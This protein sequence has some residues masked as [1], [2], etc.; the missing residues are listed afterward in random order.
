MRA[1]LDA[2]GATNTRI[3]VTS[4]LDEFSIAA[5]AA[6]PVDGYGVGTQLV[7]GSG[8]PTCGFVYK[9]VAREDDHGEMVAVAKKSKDKISIGGRKWAMRRLSSTG[10]A[11]AEVIGIGKP[12]EN[13]GDDRE[14]LVDLVRDGE[15]VGH[16]PLDAARDRHTGRPRRAPHTARADVQ[17]RARD[18]D[19]VRLTWP[20]SPVTSSPR[21]SRSRRRSPRSSRQEAENPPVLY[22]LHGLTD[23][24]TGWTAHTSIERYA[25]D[26]GLAVVMPSVHHSFYTDEVHGH[27]YFTYVADELPGLVRSLFR[28]SDRPSD[29]FA[30]G[31]VDGRLRR[32]EARAH[33]SRPV[34][35][36]RLPVRHAGHRTTWP[37]ARTARRSGTVRSTA[38]SVEPNDLFALLAAAP[39]VPPLYVGCGTSDGLLDDNERFIAAATEAGVELTTDLRPGD[40]EW[41]LWDAQ[42]ADVIAWLP[43]DG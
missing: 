27:A 26:A 39:T 16:E 40:H 6:A 9:L 4:D 33:P 14:L 18:P 2:L 11:E 8:H 43:R 41:S 34:R 36:R 37:T 23:D 32:R 13:D 3:V 5:L 22:L 17:G 1:E 38:A 7:T 15:V 25:E 20:S 21:R 28:V 12:P 30:A 31:P 42:I 35:R 10:V 19:A 29:T 24:H